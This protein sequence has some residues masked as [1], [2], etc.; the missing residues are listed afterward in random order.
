MGNKGILTRARIVAAT[1]DLM[2]RRPLRELRVAEIGAVA[3]VSSSTFYLYFES[4][5]DA[6]LAV[7]EEIQQATPE[8][9]ALLQSEWTHDNVMAK[10]KAFVQAYFAVWDRHH[11]LLRLRNFAADEGDKRFYDARRRA[12]EP[13]HL[14]L[15][16]KIVGFQENVP[17][18]Q[19]LDPPSTVSVLLA[20]LERTAQVVRLPSQH[21][22]TRPRQIEA[23][24]F[25]IAATIQGVL[26]NSGGE[27]P[28]SRS[29]RAKA[30]AG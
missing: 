7:T 4:V 9:M 21:K 22:A 1:A 13:I 18:E 5:A 30:I 24:A 8:I 10:A 2:Q 28:T 23:A 19:R 15:Q 25:I 3:A 20:M 12:V 6:G 26:P 11:A 14:E 17:P 29:P 16:S 27:Q